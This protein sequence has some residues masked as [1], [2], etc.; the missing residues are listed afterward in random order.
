MIMFG[1]IFMETVILVTLYMV[2][3]THGDVETLIEIEPQETTR[4][5]QLIFSG[6]RLS[7]ESNLRSSYFSSPIVN[8]CYIESVGNLYLL[9]FKEET[10]P[11]I[12]CQPFNPC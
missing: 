12:I 6:K 5:Y 3:C 8:P 11:P 2:K 10:Y 1:Q 4:K 7:A 9:Q